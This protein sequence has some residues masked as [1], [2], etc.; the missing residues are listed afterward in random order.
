MSCYQFKDLTVATMI[1]RVSY[2]LFSF[3]FYTFCLLHTNCNLFSVS[4]IASISKN[5]KCMQTLKGQCRLDATQRDAT[6]RG[7]HM[8]CR[9][10]A[11]RYLRKVWMHERCLCSIFFQY[12][13][14]NVIID[15][16]DYMYFSTLPIEHFLSFK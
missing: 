11:L 1:T 15:T 10:V 9:R 3:F 13:Y 14:L 6:R 7:V 4:S 5:F 2:D 16:Y 8:A 12:L